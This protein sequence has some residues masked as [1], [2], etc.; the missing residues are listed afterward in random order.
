MEAIEA[1]CK[2][3]LPGRNRQDAIR[4]LVHDHLVRVGYL[5][6]LNE[7]TTFRDAAI[8]Q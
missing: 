4:Q 7:E 8:S 5:K 2:E 1:Y 3:S 6:G